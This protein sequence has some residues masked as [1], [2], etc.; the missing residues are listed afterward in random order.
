MGGATPARAATAGEDAG[1]A[2]MTARNA[3]LEV[4]EARHPTTDYVLGFDGTGWHAWS[5][6]IRTRPDR[7]DIDAST[8]VELDGLLAFV[9]DLPGWLREHP[10]AECHV[11]DG[12]CHGSYPFSGI[13]A[14]LWTGPVPQSGLM[15]AM[16]LLAERAAGC[17]RIERDFPGWLAWVTPEGA[18]TANRPG[19][20]N[21]EAPD[22][23]GMRAAIS[24]ATGGRS[25]PA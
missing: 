16:R 22:E 8:A 20:A 9:L 3:A 21:I 19:G 18:W 5:T 10:G 11:E 23:E 7:P 12:Q 6:V 17:G 2:E 4:L 25:W 15:A 1:A 24:N 13:G 14:R